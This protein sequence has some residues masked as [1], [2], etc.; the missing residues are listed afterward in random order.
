M[1]LHTKVLETLPRGTIQAAARLLGLLQGKTIVLDDEDQTGIIMDLAIYESLG[2]GMTALE[3]Y[4]ARRSAASEETDLLAAMAGSRTSLFEIVEARPDEHQLIYQD[5]L[6][7]IMGEIT[8]TDV[9]LSQTAQP[10]LMIFTRVVDVDGLNMSSGIGFLFKPDLKK[11]LMKR[12]KTVM[13]KIAS[14]SDSVRRFVA[15]F[16]LYGIDGLTAAFGNIG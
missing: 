12:H 6:N 1:N 14:D 16:K 13:K 11:Y 15:F 3:T 7:P 5:L 2:E 4:I 8:V 9:H 10:G